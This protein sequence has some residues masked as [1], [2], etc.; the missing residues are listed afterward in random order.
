MSQ[1]FWGAGRTWHPRSTIRVAG[2]RPSRWARRCNLWSEQRC[3]LIHYAPALERQLQIGA[4]VDL[5]RNPAILRLLKAAGLDFARVDMEHTA[6]SMESIANM[7]LLARALN[8]P[9]AAR[10]P[11]ANREWITRLL[12]VGVWNPALSAGGEQGTCRRDRRRFTLCTAGAAGRCRA[13]PG[14]RLR[15]DRHR[16]GASRVCQPAGVRDGDVRDRRCVQRSRHD[17][18]NGR[19]R[20][21][22]DRA[23]RSFAGPRRVRHAR[24]GAGIGRE[25]RPGPGGGEER[26]Q[27]V[28]DAVLQL[29]AGAAV[30]DSRRIVVGVLSPAARC[31]TGGT[32]RRWRG[33]R[34]RSRG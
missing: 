16:R 34:G 24:P 12:D 33:S 18:G 8:F 32:A 30:E 10:P 31:C 19:D 7:A 3:K 21:A 27:D 15:H 11:K 28:R 2:S 5:V 6:A 26:R 23:S 1:R 25:A 22:N 29:R 14:H 17:R 20:R 13:Q 9:I 4:W